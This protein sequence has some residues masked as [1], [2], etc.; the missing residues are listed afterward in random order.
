[1]KMA[2]SSEMRSPFSQNATI[3]QPEIFLLRAIQWMF[4]DGVCFTANN[5]NIRIL[6]D[7]HRTI[8]L[9]TRRNR[10][11][12]RRNHPDIGNMLRLMPTIAQPPAQGR[13]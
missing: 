11:V 3:A 4:I 1:M 9:R 2:I 12:V 13:R 8:R 5:T 10:D 6:A 7:Q